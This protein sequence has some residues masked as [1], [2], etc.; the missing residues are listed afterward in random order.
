[1]EELLLFQVGT[2][3]LGIDLACIKS[4]QSAKPNFSEQKGQNKRL[5]QVVDG[6]EIPL[7]DLLSVFE[8]DTALRDSAGEKV[9]A[10]QSQNYAM[11]LIVDRINQVVPVDSDLIKPLSPI[12]R[13]SS[14]ACFPKVLKHDNR[15]V[16]LF[17]PEGF[18]E[19]DQQVLESQN[20][21]DLPDSEITSHALEE[22]AEHAGEVSGVYNQ[23]P[24]PHEIFQKS[25]ISLTETDK[26]ILF[27]D[28]APIDKK[29]CGMLQE[30]L[31]AA[32]VEKFATETLKKAKLNDIINRMFIQ[33]AEDLCFNL[34]KKKPTRQ[35]LQINSGTGQN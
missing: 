2:L 12:F 13:G 10:V 22:A 32:K 34:K 24:V 35:Q 17:S 26:G 21:S 14:L 15:L 27:S 8:K 23:D 11:G 31:L 33:A 6:K 7:Y 28:F 30:D 29:V 20:Y 5:T 9:I 19:I 1:M 3:Q 4:I 18:L 25:E 16:L